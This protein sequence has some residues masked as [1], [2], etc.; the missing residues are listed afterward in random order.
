[1]FAWAKSK[2]HYVVA[3]LVAGVVGLFAVPAHAAVDIPDFGID[4]SAITAEVATAVVPPIEAAI[5]IA[6]A[7]FVVIFCMKL[8]FRLLQAS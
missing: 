7:I 5:G 6:T 3:T 1:M 8:L 4:W 2:V